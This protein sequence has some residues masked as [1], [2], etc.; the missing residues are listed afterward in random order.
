[1]KGRNFQAKL[2]KSA[3]VWLVAI[4]IILIIDLLTNS[5]TE[6]EGITW[7]FSHYINMA[8][9]GVLKNPNL[10]APYA[11]RPLPSLIAG[12]LSRIFRFSTWRSFKLLAYAGASFNAL[13]LFWLLEKMGFKFKQ[14]VFVLVICNLQFFQL[15]FL[16]FDPFRPDHLIFS[17]INLAYLAIL[18]NSPVVLSL[19]TSLGLL[20]RE[21][22][23]IPLIAFMVEK[24]WRRKEA[25]GNTLAVGILPL[26]VFA[27]LRLLIPVNGSEMYLETTSV[28]NLT[29][30]ILNILTDWKRLLNILFCLAGFALPLLMLFTHKRWVTAWDL[31]DENY[32][33]LIVVHT[34]VTFALVL[35]GGTD[36]GRFIVY[37]Y[38]PTA[39]LLAS[40]FA[41]SKINNVEMGLVFIG[42]LVFNRVLWQVPTTSLDGYLDF[43]GGYDSRVNL[44][45][46]LR[47]MEVTGWVGV[48][49]GLRWFFQRKR[50]DKIYRKI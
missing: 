32:R 35:I 46:G 24:I 30:S 14:I 6:F 16:L 18:Y 39:M 11:Y 36:L 49:F 38:V 21:F 2:L 12:W 22:I 5:V 41:S 33:L 26:F 23:V 45:S 10:V 4:A 9:A 28:N 44:A 25:L 13:T 42:V 34:L 7:D 19:V 40:M 29:Q 37:L 31:L 47:A 17:L 1:M 50:S 27:G 43:Y 20:M 48:S 3:L 15:K 8:E